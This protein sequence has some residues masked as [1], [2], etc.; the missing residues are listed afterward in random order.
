VAKFSR[1]HVHVRHSKKA[2]HQKKRKEEAIARPPEHIWCIASKLTRACMML[3]LSKTD[4]R[5]IYGWKPHVNMTLQEDQAFSFGL[6][7]LQTLHF[8]QPVPW[9][10]HRDTS[11][12][13][14]RIHSARPVQGSYLSRLFRSAAETRN[15]P[16]H[17]RG[18]IS[19]QRT[20][21]PALQRFL[22]C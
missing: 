6:G 9:C 21:K 20:G 22:N 18:L 12:I 7:S 1:W 5:L 3:A 14:E 8:V 13:S 19:A 16:R 17:T 11:D 2:E 15:Q 10:F 4:L